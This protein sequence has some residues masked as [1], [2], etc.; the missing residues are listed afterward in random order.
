MAQ[1]AAP[2]SVLRA[3]GDRLL[4]A[5]GAF[6]LTALFFL[7]LP[8]IQ[9]IS[10]PPA[11]DL[12]VRAMDAAALPPPPATIEEDPEPEEE[13]EPEEIKLEEDLTPLDLSQLELALNPGLGDAGSLGG[14]FAVKLSTLAGAA[15]DLD[16]L[17]SVADLDQPPRAIYKP[18]PIL[19]AKLRAKSPGTVNILFVVDQG[20]RVVDPVVQSS[21]D[22]VFEAAALAAV[23]QWKFEPG[24]R[25]GQAVR[26]RMRLPM[27]FKKG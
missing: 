4:A 26:F 27:I 3:A 16:A 5:L 12:L 6:A 19:N 23:K 17:F 1:A 8:L 21:T 24:K 11:S 20:G 14:D 15:G 10:K 18:S 25:K 22:A 9:A 13:P 2:A 7:L